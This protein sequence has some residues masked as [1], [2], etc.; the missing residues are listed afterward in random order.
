MGNSCTNRFE[1][2]HPRWFYFN[3]TIGATGTT[4]TGLKFTVVSSGVTSANNTVS[5]I[6]QVFGQTVGD[7]APTPQIIYDESGDAN[8]NNFNDDNSPPVADGSDYI[9]GTDT[10]IANDP[11]ADGVDTFGNNT[12]TG[13]DGELNVITISPTDDILNGTQGRPDAIG[14]IDD[15]DDFTNK[16]TPTPPA[17]TNPTDLF[18]PAEITFNNSLKNPA[19]SGFI[20]QT[21]VE[22]YRL[23]KLR[24]LAVSPWAPMALTPTFLMAQR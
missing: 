15:N 6:A 3:G 13:P 21:T 19:A 14:P 11:D 23:L 24:L 2:G 18:D 8:P 16:S 9:P 5:N 12:G 22:L 7:P 17:G 20:A 4:L 10:G 1:H